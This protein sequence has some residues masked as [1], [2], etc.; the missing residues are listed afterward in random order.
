MVNKRKALSGLVIGSILV[1]SFRFLL[2]NHFLT[3][4]I[5]SNITQKHSRMLYQ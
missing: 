4:R 2:A 5:R 1:L 3:K